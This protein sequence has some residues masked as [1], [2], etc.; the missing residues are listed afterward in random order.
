[1]SSESWKQ[2]LIEEGRKVTVMKN[3]YEVVLRSALET[4]NFEQDFH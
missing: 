2:P 3:D 4:K 1:M